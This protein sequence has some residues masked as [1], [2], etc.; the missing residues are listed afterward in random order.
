MTNTTDLIRRAI[1]WLALQ[2]NYG[3][4]TQDTERYLIPGTGQ[5]LYPDIRSHRYALTG[6]VEDKVREVGRL[7]IDVWPGG[8]SADWDVNASQMLKVNF[9]HKDPLIARL[10]SLMALVEKID[11]S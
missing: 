3:T 8:S 1:D 2:R 10:G 4:G 9:E 5:Y 6:L 7:F 11:E